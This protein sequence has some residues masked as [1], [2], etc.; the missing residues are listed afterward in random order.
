MVSKLDLFYRDLG[1]ALLHFLGTGLM[2][3]LSVTGRETTGPR[4]TGS[5]RQRMLPIKN[6]PS[7]LNNAINLAHFDK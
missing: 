7:D 3:I 4:K 1:M 6:V 5:S 2:K